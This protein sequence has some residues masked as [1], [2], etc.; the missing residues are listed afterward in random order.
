MSTLLSLSRLLACLSLA[1]MLVAGLCV[2]AAGMHGMLNNRLPYGWLWRW[3]GKAENAGLWAM[4][5]T[6]LGVIVCAIA[7]ALAIVG[8]PR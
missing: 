8:M 3:S 6:A 7:T 2:F 4:G 5:L 1:L